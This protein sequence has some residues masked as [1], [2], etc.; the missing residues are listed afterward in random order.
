[1]LNCFIGIDEVGYGPILGPLVVCFSPF[2]TSYDYDSF[3]KQ[4][5]SLLSKNEIVSIKDSKE[6]FRGRNKHLKLE[7]EM[8][9]FLSLFR[10]PFVTYEEFLGYF[11]KNKILWE[12]AIWLEPNSKLP[13]FSNEEWTSIILDKRSA[14]KTCFMVEYTRAVKPWVFQIEPYLFNKMLENYPTKA[15]LITYSVCGW[16]RRF[17]EIYGPD[18]NLVFF[19]GRHGGRKFYYSFLARFFEKVEIL[20]ERDTYSNYRVFLE[21]MNLQADLIFITNAEQKS[22]L[23]AIASMIAKYF[24]EL[25]MKCLNTFFQRYKPLKPTS[26]YLPDAL[27]FLD[28]IKEIIHKLNID[29]AEVVRK[30]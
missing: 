25:S 5:T 30:V 29:Y 11:L 19:I 7:L 15:D 20:N 8:L 27:T 24:R 28:D 6:F 17:M 14:F 23:V 2:V 1:M 9:S 3:S 26:G 12:K 10:N 21:N 13:F 22:Y 4:L 16:I 18:F